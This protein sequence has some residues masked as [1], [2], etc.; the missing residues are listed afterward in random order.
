MLPVIDYAINYD[1]IAE[2]L[3]ENKNKPVLACYGK[4]YLAKE[5][6]K[7]LPDSPIG[8]NSRTPKID[9]DKY[10]VSLLHT[11]KCQLFDEYVSSLTIDKYHKTTPQE[12]SFSLLR[13]PQV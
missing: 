6:Q 13:P 1:Y 10:P 4:C 11:Y 12:Y 2:Q 5:V 9:V 3:C 7:T 8:E